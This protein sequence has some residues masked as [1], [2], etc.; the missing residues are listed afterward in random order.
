[1]NMYQYIEHIVL[2]DLYQQVLG[3]ARQKFLLFLFYYE[4][5]IFCIVDLHKNNYEL[6]DFNN[7]NNN[8]WIP[9]FSH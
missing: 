9:Q 4:F 8:L 7:K 2:L 5:L 3:N 6:R 1:M